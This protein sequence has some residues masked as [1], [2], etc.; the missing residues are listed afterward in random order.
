MRSSI[1]NVLHL[2]TTSQS[3]ILGSIVSEQT[4]PSYVSIHHLQTRPSP[5]LSNC[6]CRCPVICRVRRQPRAKRVTG[7]LLG[8]KTDQIATS[9]HSTSHPLITQSRRQHIPM[10]IDST[11]D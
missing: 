3:N 5:L 11:E 2:K 1:I 6:M 10:S 8:I 4:S 7:E 9:F